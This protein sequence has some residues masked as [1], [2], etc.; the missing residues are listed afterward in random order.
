VAEI[1][2]ESLDECSTDWANRPQNNSLVKKCYSSPTIS[3]FIIAVVLYKLIGTGHLQENKTQLIQVRF[4]YVY[5]W[6]NAHLKLN[7]STNKSSQVNKD[8]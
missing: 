4:H 5:I 8:D 3:I 7:I 6:T 2:L 1:N